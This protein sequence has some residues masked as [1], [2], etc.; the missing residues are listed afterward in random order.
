MVDELSIR[1]V[2]LY[3]VSQICSSGTGKSGALNTKTPTVDIPRTEASKDIAFDVYA[4]TCLDNNRIA[5]RYI[6]HF[7]HVSISEEKRKE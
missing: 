1:P 6:I 3:R 2:V 4:N 5:G 7:I